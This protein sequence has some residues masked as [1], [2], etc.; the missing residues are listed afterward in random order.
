MQENQR[1]T[2]LPDGMV[3]IE[4]DFLT[5]DDGQTLPTSLHF[6]RKDNPKYFKIINRSIDE[7]TACI[8]SETTKEFILK[9][10][11]EGIQETLVQFDATGQETHKTQI[12]TFKS[13]NS[14]S[15][16]TTEFR[17][18][19][20]T[21]TQTQTI[22]QDK[23]EGKT[24]TLKQ[25]YPSGRVHTEQSHTEQMTGRKIQIRI[26]YADLAHSNAMTFLQ[27]DELR[28]NQTRQKRE[29]HF[30]PP[31][32]T[33]FREIRN[34]S[35][36]EEQPDNIDASTFE[37][38][39]LIKQVTIGKLKGSQQLGKITTTYEAFETGFKKTMRLEKTDDQGQFQM[40]G[41]DKVEHIS[42]LP[43]SGD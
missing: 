37:K 20:H 18:N 9:D 35:A 15:I 16:K 41:K 43:G 6:S 7:N 8:T 2:Q 33:S 42:N 21:P 36:N 10:Q 4:K 1:I 38:G 27:R 29:F 26:E 25:F 31:G 14:T 19:T 5:C 28:P 23:T 30:N 34:Y 40:V 39:Q 32:T 22:I 11:I 24:T 13:S 3:Q 12:E 17:P